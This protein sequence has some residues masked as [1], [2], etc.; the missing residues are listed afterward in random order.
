LPF[1]YREMNSSELIR[2]RQE[3]ANQYKSHWKSRDASEVTYR[4]TLKGNNTVSLSNYHPPVPAAG[5][6]PV[7]GDT[8]LPVRTE[9]DT[10]QGPG[11]GFSPDYSI[12]TVQ[13]RVAGNVVCCDYGWSINGGINLQTCDTISDILNTEKN[14]VRGL[15]WTSGSE[16]SLTGVCPPNYSPQTPHFAPDPT[17]ANSTTYY[18]TPDP[19]NVYYGPLSTKKDQRA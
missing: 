4:N 11:N 17:C 14:T 16:Q 10:P 5:S 9:C 19:T 8:S 18:V 2:R 12:T 13:N 7:S 1:T 3:A 15:T 6:T